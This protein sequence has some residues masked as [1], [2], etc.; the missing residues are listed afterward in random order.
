MYHQLVK[1]ELGGNLPAFVS[2]TLREA[3]RHN[4]Y[5]HIVIS[6]QYR[7]PSG[8]GLILYRRQR[9]PLGKAERARMY[10]K[11]CAIR[12]TWG[13][14]DA[15]PRQLTKADMLEICDSSTQLAIASFTAEYGDDYVP[16][17]MIISYLWKREFINLYI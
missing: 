14:P 3:D 7:H 16:D 4:L 12:D 10:L 15:V 11:A 13:V 1:R 5:N 6:A 2:R 17:S 9:Y 8:F